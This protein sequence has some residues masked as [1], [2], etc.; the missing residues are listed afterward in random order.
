[1]NGLHTMYD[2][3]WSFFITC[4]NIWISFFISATNLLFYPVS[5]LYVKPCR[6][7]LHRCHLIFC[8][9]VW[10][11]FLHYTV[12]GQSFTTALFSHH[13]CISL[14]LSQYKYNFFVAISRSFG[15]LVYRLLLTVLFR[16]WCELVKHVYVYVSRISHLGWA[17]LHP[18]PQIIHW[19]VRGE[20]FTWRTEIKFTRKTNLTLSFFCDRVSSTP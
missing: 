19:T 3:T 1:M 11:V 6:D 7:E 4:I 13:I 18:V 8:C 12:F 14:H 16:S 5:P 9:L 10:K 17:L 15:R 2:I 20:F